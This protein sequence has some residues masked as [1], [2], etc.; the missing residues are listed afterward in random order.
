MNLMKLFNFNYLKENLK[1]SRGLLLFLLIILPVLN[2]T[3]LALSLVN[4]KEPELLSFQDLSFI[5]YLGTYII[6]VILAFLLLGFVFKKKNVDFVLSKPISRTNIYLTNVV[7]GIG[8]IFLLIVLNAV[9]FGVFNLVSLLVIPF[10]LIIDYLI[11]WLIS[12]IFVFAI[13]VLAITIAGNF[14]SSLVV[15]LIITCLFPFFYLSNILLFNYNSYD[16]YITCSNCQIE[17]YNCYGNE[18]CLKHLNNNEYMFDFEEIPK[19]NFTVPL[20]FL[21]NDDMAYNHISLIKMVGLSIIYLILG[22]VIFLKRKMENNETSFKYEYM[23]YIVK[24]IT[25]IPICFITYFLIKDDTITG[26]VLSILGIII[27]SIIYDFITRKEIYKFGKSTFISLVIFGILMGVYS[28]V[29]N[30]PGAKIL[31]INDIEYIVYEY[32]D[33]DIKITDKNLINSII[34]DNDKN[35]SGVGLEIYANTKRYQAYTNISTANRDLLDEI[36]ES[37]LQ[38]EQAEFDIKHFDYAEDLKVDHKLR[39]LIE[40]AYNDANFKNSS[41]ETLIKVYDYKNH[42]YQ[43]LSIPKKINSE[44]DNYVLQ[45]RT[46]NALKYLKERNDLYLGVS[47]NFTELDKYVFDYV[48][49]SN[50]DSFIDYLENKNTKLTSNELIIYSYGSPSFNIPIG[51]ATSFIKEFNKYKEKLQND[52]DY[53]ELVN[54]YYELKEEDYV[55]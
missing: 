25:L 13:T 38:K 15:G 34:L 48:I 3:S 32:Q 40:D 29:N 10:K 36:S 12:Y 18:I 1:K 27:Y 8:L 7:G 26:Y 19:G 51:D 55:D 53:Q 21:N 2:I 5:T 28:L 41:N 9:I 33:H 20:L 49:N 14:M 45:L 50:I 39:K 6:P 43:E 54:H 35:I 17:N 52:A 42:R 4:M 30:I 47:T 11:Y 16:S 23:H 46:K 31:D 22:Y 24:G 37:Q 44:L